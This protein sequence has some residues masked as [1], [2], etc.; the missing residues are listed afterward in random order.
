MYKCIHTPMDI[1]LRVCERV[2]EFLYEGAY[3]V[4]CNNVYMGKYFLCLMKINHFN[5]RLNSYIIII[6]KILV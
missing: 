6:I 5:N 4:F 1:L 2:L 3:K